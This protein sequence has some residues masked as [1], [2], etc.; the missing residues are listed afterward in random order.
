[1]HATPLGDHVGDGRNVT[2]VRVSWTARGAR[3][4]ILALEGAA[5][6]RGGDRGG[7][8]DA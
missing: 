6:A 5:Q 8:V 2:T 1:M 7:R 3:E 4:A